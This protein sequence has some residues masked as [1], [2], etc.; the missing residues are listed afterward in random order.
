MK[1]LKP[2]LIFL[3]AF[4][5][6]VAMIDWAAPAWEAHQA[7]LRRD[8]IAASC[9]AL[10]QGWNKDYPALAEARRRYESVTKVL[11]KYP[12]ATMENEALLL[13]RGQ[14]AREV[15]DAAQSLNV[16]TYGA[17]EEC[18]GEWRA[19]ADDIKATLAGS[20]SEMSPTDD[21]LDEACAGRAIGSGRFNETDGS[22]RENDHGAR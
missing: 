21:E 22:E 2:A 9:S 16:W 12:E 13:L 11:A 20:G 17:D 8:R 14:R 6:L 4:V 7:S 5:G 3:A 1:S 18:G 10:E 15:N 19:R